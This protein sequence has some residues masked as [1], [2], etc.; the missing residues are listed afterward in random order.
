MYIPDSVILENKSPEVSSRM[1]STRNRNKGK[2]SQ[3]KNLRFDASQ[4]T[5]QDQI[6]FV[7][8]SQEV[9][10]DAPLQ[11]AGGSQTDLLQVSTDVFDEQ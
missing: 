7:G 4:D 9:A 11:G 2:K 6:T 10:T 5:S 3:R 8:H 1:S